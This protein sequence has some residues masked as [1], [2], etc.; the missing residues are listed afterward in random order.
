MFHP[1]WLSQELLPSAVPPVRFLLGREPFVT[2]E[3]H[4]GGWRFMLPGIVSV[5]F[6]RAGRRGWVSG[7]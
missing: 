7:P 3:L 2:S 6:N 5:A 1:G 4:R